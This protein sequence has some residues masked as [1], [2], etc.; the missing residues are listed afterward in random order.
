MRP[1]CRCGRAGQWR[2]APGVSADWPRSFSHIG[3]GS[4]MSFWRNGSSAREA[5]AQIIAL[6]KS[7]AVI[8]FN[9][10]GTIIAANQNFLD[11]VGYRLDEIKGKHHGMFVTPE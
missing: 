7:Q 2:R 4:L 6:S 9:L 5:I 10:D 8:E 11:A 3:R 1:F